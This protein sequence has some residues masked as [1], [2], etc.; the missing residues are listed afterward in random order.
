[1]NWR[2]DLKPPPPLDLDYEA[3]V[4]HLATEHTLSYE[5]VPPKKRKLRRF[6]YHEFF[7]EGPLL[8]RIR[9]RRKCESEPPKTGPGST[10][11]LTR[12]RW[13]RVAA[14]CLGRSWGSEAS[15]KGFVLMQNQQYEAACTYL[16]EEVHSMQP[17]LRV[18]MCWNCQIVSR[19]ILRRHSCGCRASS[20]HC[21][22]PTGTEI[23]YKFT[24]IF[25]NAQT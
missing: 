1:M 20:A 17:Q 2:A 18:Q 25:F 19:M 4:A 15:R 23:S 3:V 5:M 8:A 21:P 9:S 13:K 22:R 16:L 24:R 14:H 10:N 7:E 11:E 6:F 12:E